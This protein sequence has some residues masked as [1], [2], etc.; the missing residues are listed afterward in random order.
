MVL[1]DGRLYVTNQTGT[2]YV[3]QPDPES[4]QLIAKNELKESS[5]AT[6]AFSAGEIFIRTSKALYCIA[7]E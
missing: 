5:N 6:P 7:K 3:I 2:T 4:F 1:A